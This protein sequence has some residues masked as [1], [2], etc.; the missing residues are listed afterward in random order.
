[1]KKFNIGNYKLPHMSAFPFKKVVEE[2]LPE[3]DRTPRRLNVKKPV[4]L[5]QTVSSSGDNDSIAMSNA[6]KMF[7]K[8]YLDRTTHPA[9]G[10][11]ID[12]NYNINELNRE[13]NEFYLKKMNDGSYVPRL[14]PTDDAEMKD[15]DFLSKLEPG[16]LFTPYQPQD[17]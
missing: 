9:T 13:G 15:Q 5:K 7:N 11:P 14:I 8:G 1:M 16:Q 12:M 6:W 2:K 17:E 4:E 3:F 10:K